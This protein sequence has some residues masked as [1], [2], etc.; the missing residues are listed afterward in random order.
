M[1]AMYSMFGPNRPA[2]FLAA[3]IILVGT[4]TMFEWVRAKPAMAASPLY[5]CPNEKPD[6][7]YSSKPRPGC[8]PWVE[9]KERAEQ[10]QQ[11]D[12]AQSRSAPREIKI[13]NLQSEVSSFLQKYRRFLE[14]CKTDF[15]ELQQVEAL[16]DEV[17]GLLEA[18]Q[19]NLSNH[20][21]A[22]R[23]IMLRE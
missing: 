2:L 1:H 4:P 22:S 21:M 10:P 19:A 14:C 18:A 5:W 23:G 6:Q 17:S 9:K 20:S 3:L 16:G 7:Q 13:E 11:D 12:A 8:V 15:S